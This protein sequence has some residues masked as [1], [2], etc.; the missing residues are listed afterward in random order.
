MAATTLSAQAEIDNTRLL[1]G[2]VNLV[3]IYG[4]AALSALLQI[5]TRME[6]DKGY[7]PVPEDF[8]AIIAQGEAA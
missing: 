4:E 2:I 3:E 7:L 6:Q 1:F 5:L 8:K